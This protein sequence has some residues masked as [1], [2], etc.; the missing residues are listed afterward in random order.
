MKIGATTIPLAGWVADPRR[1][2][3]SRAH[4]LAA[5]RQLV[6]GYAL[7]AVEL[8]LD[9]IETPCQLIPLLLELIAM[10]IY[11]IDLLLEL[12]GMV[13]QPGDL[14]VQVRLHLL[15]LVRYLLQPLVGALKLAVDLLEALC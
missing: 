6:G 11:L 2:E 13:V 4:R 9:L 14:M 1:P 3:Q 8:T 7:S 5:I 15:A 12:A 10:L